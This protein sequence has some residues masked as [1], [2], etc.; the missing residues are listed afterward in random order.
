MG[1][2]V[3]EYGAHALSFSG[4]RH[5]GFA[6]RLPHEFSG[7]MRQRAGIC[8]ALIQYPTLLL[9]DEPFSA[10]DAITREEINIEFLRIWERDR[11]TAMFSRTAFPRP[12]SYRIASLSSASARLG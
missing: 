6:D 12:S 10:L 7:G 11:K 2:S 4:F 8:R 3:K 1:E 9:M 5:R